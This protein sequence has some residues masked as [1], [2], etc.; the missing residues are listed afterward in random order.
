MDSSALKPSIFDIRSFRREEEADKKGV[1]DEE[2]FYFAMATSKGW[3]QFSS[4][5]KEVVE[6]L[7]DFNSTAIEKGMSYEDIGKN[8]IVISLAKGIIQRLLNR[9][10]DSKDAVEA[11]NDK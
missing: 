2:K 8:T 7:E 11:E 5:T 3:Q 1:T 4:F 6:E 10:N 9:V